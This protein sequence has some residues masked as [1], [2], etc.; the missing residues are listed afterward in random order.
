M[1]F[2]VG[3]RQ[4]LNDIVRQIEIDFWRDAC[5]KLLERQKAIKPGPAMD[6]EKAVSLLKM[7]LRDIAKE[8]KLEFF[9]E[10]IDGIK[11]IALVPFAVYVTVDD[12]EQKFFVCVPKMGQKDFSFYEWERTAN[13]I[14]DYIAIDIKPLAEKVEKANEIFYLGEKSAEIAKASIKAL[15]D[16][17]LTQRGINCKLSSSFLKSQ[18]SICIANTSYEIDVFH[19]PF[20]KDAGPLIDLLQNPREIGIK[21]NVICKKIIGGDSMI[22]ETKSRKHRHAL[23]NLEHPGIITIQLGYALLPITDEEKGAPIMKNIK[24]CRSQ[25]YEEYGLVLPKIVVVDSMLLDPC[26]YSII[27]SGKEIAKGACKVDSEHSIPL[28][29]IFK[30]NIGEILNQSLVNKLVNKSRSVNPDVVDDVFITHRFSSSRLKMILNALLEQAV[31]IRSMSLILETIAD[32]IDNANDVD[33]IVS[34]IKERL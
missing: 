12:E 15:C 20:S 34:K 23:S 24:L 31:S 33:F 28:T 26:E 9:D 14:R 18:I 11:K 22:Y 21:D 16:S 7:E 30:E 4:E 19:K 2:E 32:F 13:W 17:Y 29:K 6:A 8:Y 10:C 1:F 3:P 5:A 25:I 27:I